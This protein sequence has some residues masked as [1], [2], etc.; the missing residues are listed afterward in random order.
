MQSLHWK[1]N[2]RGVKMRDLYIKPQVEFKEFDILD[3]VKCSPT[4]VD[5]TEK[6]GDPDGD[7]KETDA[8]SHLY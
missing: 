3:I 1:K 8:W 5:P 7:N 2:R 4:P 6:P